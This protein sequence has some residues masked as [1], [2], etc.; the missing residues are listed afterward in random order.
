MLPRGAV[1]RGRR[2][3]QGRRRRR[4]AGARSAEE[5]VSI[6]A[7]RDPR[8]AARAALPPRQSAHAGAD[9]RRLAALPARPRARRHGAR[10]GPEGEQRA[11]AVRA[12]RRARM[13]TGTAQGP[14]VRADGRSRARPRPRSRSR[15]TITIT[16][17]NTD[18]DTATRTGTTRRAGAADDD[19]HPS[20][21]L[22]LPR[23]STAAVTSPALPV[24]AFAYS[25]RARSAPSPRAIVTTR[26]AP[27]DWI[28]GRAR[29][30]VCRARRAGACCACMR[31]PRATIAPSVQ[32]WTRILRASSRDRGAAARGRQMG[33]R[34]ARL[35]VDPRRAER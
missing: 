18:T 29:R 23:C 4:R 14:P 3:A 11:S 32:R 28:A 22:G 10:A 26:R 12:R 27:R 30:S 1:L 19:F 16:T 24:G 13:G 7:G 9:R 2:L 20:S 15:S 33:A 5:V 35:L 34:L 21:G 8:A 25:Q 6:A 17:T 31:L